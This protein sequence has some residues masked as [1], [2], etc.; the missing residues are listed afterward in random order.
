MPN[1]GSGGAASVHARLAGRDNALNAVRLLLATF[2]VVDHSFKAATG[3]SG[4]WP[5]LGAFAVDGFFAISGYLIAGSRTR[6]GMRPFLWR[7][8][9]RLM[10]AYWAVLL[11]TAL[12][13]A[14]VSTTMTRNAY[15][16]RSAA[17]YVVKNSL[18]VTTQ[19][20]IAGTPTDVAYHGLWNVSVWSLLYEAAAYVAFGLV[21]GAVWFRIRT[22]ALLSAGLAVCIVV[23]FGLG[24][25]PD[26]LRDL[27]RLW[28]FFAAGVL[29]WF[30]R[31]RLP[32]SRAVA[33]VAGA[34]V[35]AALLLDGTW[36]L[37]L[38]PV[39][40]AFVLLWLGARLPVRV[41]ARNDISYGVY[42]FAFPLQQ[43]MAVGRVPEVVGSFWFAVLS[44]A[45]TVPVAWASWL[46]VEKPSMRLRRVV[47]V[48][49]R[50]A[51][52]PSATAAEVL[53]RP[54]IG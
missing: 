23:Q 6:M 22:A 32:G 7:R 25:G 37:M 31:E 47:P 8:A 40:L 2:V 24:V 10:P 33:A 35:V 19:M 43:L 21:I 9:L 38:A 39:P 45:V 53:G 15:D 42:V 48:G 51:S 17:S 18:L 20:G 1:W 50:P 49:T 34:V 4:P 46:L 27:T 3:E 54:V 14:P 41:G 36:Y 13:A 28:S 26:A 30:F 5:Y 12:V 11:F 52:A 29:L 44:V 16:W